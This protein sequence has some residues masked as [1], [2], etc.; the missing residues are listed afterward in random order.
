MKLK[1]P[2]SGTDNQTYDAATRY[3]LKREAQGTKMPKAKKA[4]A[5][6]IANFD[7]SDITLLVKRLM[8][9]ASTIPAT[10]SDLRSKLIFVSP[11]SLKQPFFARLEVCTAFRKA[12]KAS[13]YR[14]S[15]ARKA[16]A[17]GETAPF[18]T[19]ATSILRNCESRT[20]QENRQTTSS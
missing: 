16:L 2:C 1:G 20:G 19:Q 18:I 12:S 10:T 4:K 14:I 3:F 8:L 13:S 9:S 15:C 5:E 7:V 6:D 11:A 17:L